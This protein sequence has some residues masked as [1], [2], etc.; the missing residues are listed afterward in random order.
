L[1]GRRSQSGRFE[2][3]PAQASSLSLYFPRR[4]APV[5]HTLTSLQELRLEWFSNVRNDLLVLQIIAGW[6]RLGTLKRFVSRSVVLT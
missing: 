3:P 2:L 1:I 6:L 5:P 4:R